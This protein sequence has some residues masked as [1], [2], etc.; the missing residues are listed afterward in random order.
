[1]GR[2]VEYGLGGGM[3]E[4]RKRKMVE[5]LD[6]RMVNSGQ[7][8]GML[9]VCATGCCCGRT[10]RGFDEVDETLYHAE[11]ESRR[12]RNRVH[13]NQGG[14]LGPCVLANVVMLVMDG[15]PVWFHSV[16]DRAI[17]HAMFDYIESLLEDIDAQPPPVPRPHLF[18][19]FAWNGESGVEVEKAIQPAPEGRGEGILF[20]ASRIRIC[21][22][23]RGQGRCCLRAL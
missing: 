17:V 5:R 11:W 18:N 10:E 3:V 6:G 19:G 8:R 7:L 12:L 2:G 23:W 9:F 13:L 20:S 21:W 22:R 15:R 4:I 16:N 14:C 1:M